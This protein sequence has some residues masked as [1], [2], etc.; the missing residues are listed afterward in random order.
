MKCQGHGMAGEMIRHGQRR[1]REVYKCPLLVATLAPPLPAFH[2]GACQ[3]VDNIFRPYP[4]L[5]YLH[6][7]CRSRP[8]FAKVQ[9]DGNISDC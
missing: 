1:P 5:V 7:A 6:G 2:A 8:A 9:H 3:T 4:R